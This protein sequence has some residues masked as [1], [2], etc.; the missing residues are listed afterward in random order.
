MK[1]SRF[2]SF[3]SSFCSRFSAPC[4]GREDDCKLRKAEYAKRTP[5]L[6][7]LEDR[8]LPS[9]STTIPSVSQ[10]APLVAWPD[11]WLARIPKGNPTVVLMGDSI[12]WGYANGTGTNVWNTYLA[13]LG[14]ADY[15][16]V[17][18]TTQSLLFQMSLG[19][20]AG[21]NPVEVSVEIGANNLLQDES[22]QDAAAGVIA[23]VNMVHLFLPQA[24]VLVLGVF[25]G[26][27]SPG[28]PYRSEGAQTNQLV[29]QMLAGDPRATFLDLGWIFLQPDGSISNTMLFDY[30]HPTELG[31]QALTNLLQPMI[32]QAL[33]PYLITVYPYEATGFP[34][35]TIPI[36][37]TGVSLRDL[38]PPSGIS[39]VTQ[40]VSSP[41][42][43]P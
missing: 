25:P 35:G 10:I 37:L 27:Q 40:P 41:P 31:Y 9:V 23:D 2:L 1:S 16:V 33:L 14:V 6:E 29:S 39:T 24:H 42:I 22:P 19:V 8:C 11:V 36:D 26:H 38:I 18:Q 21:I 7:M 4:R 32:E 28:D 12:S 17:G 15:G 20:L 30:L 34:S 13:P 43:T 3:V 5:R